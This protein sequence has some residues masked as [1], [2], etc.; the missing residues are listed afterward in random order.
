[1]WLTLC[2]AE[3]AAGGTHAAKARRRVPHVESVELVSR[4]WRLARPAV[5][6]RLPFSAVLWL[7]EGGHSR[8]SSGPWGVRHGGGGQA[9]PLRPRR[10]INCRAPGAGNTILPPWLLV[11][12]LA[13]SRQARPDLIYY[14]F[15]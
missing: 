2:V 11:V 15:I 13:C 3:A 8:P 1:M 7:A 12:L 6:E 9:R 10:R 5:F 14:V 4:F